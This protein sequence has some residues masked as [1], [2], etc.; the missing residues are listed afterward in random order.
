MLGFL[1][2]EQIVVTIQTLINPRAAQLAY[3]TEGNAPLGFLTAP[4]GWGPGQIR[5]LQLW[6]NAQLAGQPGERAKLIWR[7]SCAAV[8]RAEDP[9]SRTTLTSGWPDRRLRLLAAADPVRAP[10]EPRHRRR[11]PGS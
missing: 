6:L 11:G 4:V 8:H 1:L 9:P 10:D 7:H 3:F 2:V 5:E